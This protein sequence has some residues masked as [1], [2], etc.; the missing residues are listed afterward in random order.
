[1]T[2]KSPYVLDLTVTQRRELEVRVR[3]YTSPHRDVLRAKIVLMA[4]QVLDNDEITCQLD[5][6]GFIVSKWRTR[7][8][9]RGLLALEEHLRGG[10]PRVLFPECSTFA[11]LRSPGPTLE[12]QQPW[13][14][15]CG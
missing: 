1:M 11:V 10:R 9:E 3:R 2:R 15:D 8:F 6:S 14:T 5:T 7:L 4:A 13:I 12:T